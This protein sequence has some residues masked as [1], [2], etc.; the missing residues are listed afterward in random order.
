[1]VFFDSLKNSTRL[2]HGPI[3]AK[4]LAQNGQILPS[5]DNNWTYDVRFK[6]RAADYV[7]K[8]SYVS[9]LGN[10]TQFRPFEPILTHFWVQ[11]GKID[12]RFMFRTQDCMEK[13]S[14]LPL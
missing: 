13:W 4:I 12:V 14:C 7:E 1:M 3:L 8:W 11:M 2:L 9:I 10:S 6:L 5:K